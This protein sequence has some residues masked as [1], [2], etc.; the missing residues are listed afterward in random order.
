MNRVVNHKWSWA[1]QFQKLLQQ[2]GHDQIL[3]LPVAEIQK[4]VP[5]L[6]EQMCNLSKTNIK[7]M[8]AAR[9]IKSTWTPDYSKVKSDSEPELYI[10]N[11]VTT[12]EASLL[13]QARVN[14]F[15]ICWGEKRATL[16]SGENCP[17]CEDP[18]ASLDHY[19]FNCHE[20]VSQRIQ[21]L[22][23]LDANDN[24]F[25]DFY[26]ANYKNSKFCK[27]FLIF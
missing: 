18:V 19:L 2:T 3:N 16:V 10:K 11:E 6:L 17:W 9:V 13:A 8:D 20:L 21:L 7:N 5:I 26:N 14:L 24:N 22:G 23:K 27:Y 1:K 12:Q 15:R 25:I 4:Q